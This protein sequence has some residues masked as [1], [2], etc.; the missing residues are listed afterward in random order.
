MCTVEIEIVTT[1]RKLT[2]NIIDQMKEIAL[3]ELD[4]AYV[5][6]FVNINPT[7]ILLEL[8]RFEYRKIFWHWYKNGNNQIYRKM[9]IWNVERNFNNEIDLDRYL[10]KLDEFKKQATQIYI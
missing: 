2:K 4:D 7:V 5:L 10:L 3:T 9:G 8:H 1:K 6:G